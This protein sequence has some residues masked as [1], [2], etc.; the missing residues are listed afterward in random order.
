[1]Q[2]FYHNP[3]VMPENKLLHGVEYGRKSLNFPTRGKY[4]LSG[5]TSSSRSAYHK[6]KRQ[7][8][9]NNSEGYNWKIR[10]LGQLKKSPDP[11]T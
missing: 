4:Q 8:Q 5:V 10:E 2:V 9:L 7:R 3:E 1:V 11:F 6:N